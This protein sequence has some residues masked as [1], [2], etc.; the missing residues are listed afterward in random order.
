M[1]NES[2]PINLRA[3]E[4]KFWEHINTIVLGIKYVAFWKRV[5]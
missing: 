1:N 2:A 5:E 3:E 4:K